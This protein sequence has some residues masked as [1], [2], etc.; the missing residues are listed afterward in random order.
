MTESDVTL[1]E[2]GRRL[3][4]IAQDISALRSESVLRAEYEAYRTATDREI[5][6]LKAEL[7][8][9]KEHEARAR[10]PWTTVVSTVATVAGLVLTILLL[11]F[12]A[13]SQP[14]AKAMPWMPA[15]T[16]TTVQA[17]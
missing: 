8:I 7:A 13:R 4:N 6:D 17:L 1:G 14:P 15:P 16:T 11:I 2:L 12:V 3:D 9:M 10:Q 5:R